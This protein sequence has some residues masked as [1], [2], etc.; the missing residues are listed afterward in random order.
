MKHQVLR[1]WTILPLLYLASALPSDRASQYDRRYRR[2]VNGVHYNAFEHRATGA[3]MSYVSNSGICETTPGVEQHSGYLDVGTDMHMWFWFFA[4]RN[5][6]GKAPLAMWLNGGP[7]CS[8]MIG[9]FQ[10]NGPCHFVDNSSEPTLNPYSWNTYAV[11]VPCVV[12][13]EEA[14]RLPSLIPEGCR[15]CSMSTSQLA[16]DSATGP[17]T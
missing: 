3:R 6:P 10:E 8:S 2:E 5:N 11:S 12:V 1:S 4:A 9:L 15:I 13:V 7:G 14:C 17:T 16:R